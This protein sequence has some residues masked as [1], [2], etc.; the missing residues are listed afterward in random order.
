MTEEQAIL[1]AL[2]HRLIELE[3]QV[4]GLASAY[5]TL[6]RRLQ[7]QEAAVSIYEIAHDEHRGRS[8]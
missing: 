8:H 2:H 1:A 6:H 3:K 7:L 4:A 5:L